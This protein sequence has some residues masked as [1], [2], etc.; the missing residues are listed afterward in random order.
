MQMNVDYS[1]VQEG[2]IST[3]DTYGTNISEDCIVIPVL[4]ALS[5]VA[6]WLAAYD[7]A[8]STSPSAAD[9]RKIA[10]VVLDAL[11]KYTEA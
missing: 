6:D 8:S 9:S 4:V 1:Q 2:N 5:E 11:K 3:E 10:R 7:P